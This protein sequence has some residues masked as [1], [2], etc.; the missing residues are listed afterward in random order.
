MTAYSALAPEL[1]LLLS[2]VLFL[3]SA[4]ELALCLYR[5]LCTGKVRYCI[6]EGLLFVPLL[7]LLS[8]AVSARSPDGAPAC[9]IRLPWLAFPLLSLAVFLQIGVGFVRERRRSRNRLS[10]NAVKEAL[11]NLDSGI[12]FA[13]ADGRVVLSNLAMNRAAFALT[14]RPPQTMDDIASALEA[15]PKSSGVV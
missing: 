9:P 5:Y 8:F 2:G 11:D 13:D 12:L 14:G 3:A 6:K 7:L 10:P 15:P 4:G 1:R